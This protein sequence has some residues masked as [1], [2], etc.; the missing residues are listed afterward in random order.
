MQP[1]DF[2]QNKFLI[3]FA[4]ISAERKNFLNISA[5]AIPWGALIEML[6]CI[7]D[8]FYLKESDQSLGQSLG[9]ES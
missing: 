1:I 9:K 6:F 2:Y 5:E 7:L 8:R 4:E 3:F